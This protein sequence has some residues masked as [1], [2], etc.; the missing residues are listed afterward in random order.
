MFTKQDK[1]SLYRIALLKEVLSE[2]KARLDEKLQPLGVTTAQLRVLWAIEENPA[3][4]GAEISRLCGVTPQTGQGF[5]T[6]LEAEGWISRHPSAL[7]DRV[8]VA[9]LTAEGKRILRRGKDIAERMDSELWSGISPQAL[10]LLES[11]L[12]NAIAKLKSL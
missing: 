2:C 8:L 12:N 10:E 3:V 1:P 6:R 4:S 7:T 9:Q 11:T 5:I